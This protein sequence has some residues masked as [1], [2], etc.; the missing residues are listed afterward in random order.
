MSQ[1][2]LAQIPATSRALA[3]DRFGE[4][5]TLRTLPMPEIGADEI[6]VRSSSARM[7]PVSSSGPVRT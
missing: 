6:L 7:R 3:I 5:G 4:P 2:T 1:E